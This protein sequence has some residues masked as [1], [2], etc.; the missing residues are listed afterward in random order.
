MIREPNS[1]ALP[2]KSFS[3]TPPQPTI[4]PSTLYTTWWNL[5]T[6]WQC[7]I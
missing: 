6:L 3:P 7:R 5:V 2:N 1:A 4:F